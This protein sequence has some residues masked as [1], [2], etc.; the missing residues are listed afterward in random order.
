MSKKS[1]EEEKNVRLLRQKWLPSVE[2]QNGK[3][4]KKGTKKIPDD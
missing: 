2:V 1:D 4:K 3:I